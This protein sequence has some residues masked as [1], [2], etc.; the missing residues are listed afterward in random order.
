M[1]LWYIW[2]IVEIYRP[3]TKLYQ[4]NIF[5]NVCLSVCSCSNLIILDLGEGSLLFWTCPYLFTLYPVLSTYWF[6]CFFLVQW[7]R[8]TVSVDFTIFFRVEDVFN[9]RGILSLLIR[10]ETQADVLFDKTDFKAS[11][12]VSEKNLA[13]LLLQLVKNVSLDTYAT[14]NWRL[15]PL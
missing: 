8:N 12:D 3:P 1:D 11:K 14:I 13:Q 4:G 9:D 6:Y 7:S 15:W 10:D 5:N 2:N